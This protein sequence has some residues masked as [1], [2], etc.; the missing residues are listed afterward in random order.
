MDDVRVDWLAQMAR[1]DSGARKN[2]VLAWGG[3]RGMK[4]AERAPFMERLL[5]NPEAL[6]HAVETRSPYDRLA[7]ALVKWL[8]DGVLAG[9]T[10]G[11][12]LAAAGHGGERHGGPATADEDARELFARG[13]FATRSQY[14]SWGELP[15]AT[16]DYRVLEHVGE[17]E[18]R[19][20]ELR[21][22]PAPAS[23]VLRRPA[24]VQL[25]ID[26]FLRAIAGLGKMTLTRDGCIRVADQR[27][28]AKA[29]G[30]EEVTSFGALDLDDPVL[31]F[32]VAGMR[33]GLLRHVDDEISVAADAESGLDAPLHRRVSRVM[34]GFARAFDWSE[35][36][37]VPDLRLYSGTTAL[38]QG[39]AALVVALRALAEPDRWHSVADLSEALFARLGER[40]GLRG[41]R[42]R[43]RWGRDAHGE[44]PE[45]LRQAA[46]S[47][48]ESTERIWLS[49]ALGTWLHALGIVEL[50]VGDREVLA[51]RVSQFGLEVLGLR[52]PA[53]PVAAETRPAWVVQPN[54]DVVLWLEQ[55]S[56][57][58]ISFLERHTQRAELRDHTV[59]YTLTREALHGGLRQ[60]STVEGLLEKLAAGSQAE[61]P[62]N[63]LAE[64][65]EW[66]QARERVVLHLGARIVEYPDAEGRDAAL[67]GGVAGDAVGERMILLRPGAPSNG[68]VCG[69]LR[70][71]RINVIYYEP[72]SG[73]RAGASC[74][75][76]LRLSTP[77]ADLTIRALLD[78][79]CEKLPD[80]T[81]QLTAESVEKARNARASARELDDLLQTRLTTSPPGLL[82]LAASAW[83]GKKV[84]VRSGRT[85]LL[86]CRDRQQ[87]NL[88]M[89][90]PVIKDGIM[91][92]VNDDMLM[93]A[94]EHADA[95][96]ERL[97][98]AGIG[99][100]KP[101]EA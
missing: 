20:I 34:M 5:G 27:K 24:A 94:G 17:P 87:R 49:W 56:S 70:L 13:L 84:E 36:A 58:Q 14:H 4:A 8:G 76:V 40:F 28:L 86:K 42:W 77:Y 81:W 101:V 52:A 79:W 32:I 50:S 25:T 46:R 100:D 29:M 91:W 11:V 43:H 61:L 69:Q 12:A 23:P 73:A 96:L 15:E 21:E 89:Q 38:T 51:F 80:G 74:D 98:W 3:Q 55:A 62:Q 47:S 90:D 53:A 48:W 2:V 44:E 16:V 75:G 22:L 1:M 95:V 97:A 6:A 63:V 35:A 31:A 45:Q 64:V 65:K 9:S 92:P 41:M 33:C 19:P 88:L 26:D 72:G 83:A 30:W 68:V 82:G 10:L 18:L 59:H 71:K 57:E 7:L 85:L 60:G 99:T 93:V 39:R 54:F 78:K 66:A 67:A 37:L